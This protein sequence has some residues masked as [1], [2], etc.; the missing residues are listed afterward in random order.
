MT[1]TKPPDFE[2]AFNLAA[3]LGDAKT[4]PILSAKDAAKLLRNGAQAFLC[5]IRVEPAVGSVS[6][7][8][9]AVDGEA[10]EPTPGLIPPERL[11][12]LK[13]EFKDVFGDPTGVPPAR[14]VGH[15]IRLVEGAGA[16]YQKPYRMSNAQE[17]EA[18]KQV[19][20]ML[21]KGWIEP[22]NSPYG[23]P[24]LFVLK[25]DG[26]MRMVIDYR[27]LNKLTIRDRYPLPRIDDML[28]RL[29][30]CSIFSAL[31]LASGYY[32]VR[33]IDSDVEKTAFIT[34]MGQM[35]FRVLPMGLCNA[36]ST[37]QR[38]VAN[39]FGKHMLFGGT[40]D[41][42]MQ[43]EGFILCY[44]DDILIASKSAEEHEQHLRFVL[45]T[46]RQHQLYAKLKKCE[47]NMPELKWVGFIVGRDGLRA[48]PAKIKAI[49]DFPLPR[50]LTQ[51]KS[52]LGLCVQLRKF[53]KH[54]SWLVAPLTDLTSLAK[55]KDFDWQNWTPEYKA[56]FQEVQKVLTTPP[57]LALVDLNQPFSLTFDASLVGSG[58]VLTQNGK[59]VAYCSR[60]FTPAEVKYST[61]ERELLALKHACEEWRCYLEGSPVE[62]L[63]DHKPL[64]SLMTKAGFAGK[65]GREERL[66]QHLSRFDFG[67]GVK[68][69]PGK[70][71]MADSLSRIHEGNSADADIDGMASAVLAVLTRAA[72]KIRDESEDTTRRAA[73]APPDQAR[74]AEALGRGGNALE[75]P[76]RKR[77][78]KSRLHRAQMTSDTPAAADEV[79]RLPQESTEPEAVQKPHKSLRLGPLA[80][81]EPAQIPAQALPAEDPIPAT[82]PTEED[83]PDIPEMSARILA[84]YA[85]DPLY[86]DEEWLS[87]CQ[88]DPDGLWHM[89]DKTMVPN[90]QALRADLIHA[91]HD[92]PLSG[93]KGTTAT[94]IAVSEHLW[95]PSLA[96]DVKDYVARCDSCQRNKPSQ[97]K[98]AGH[99]VAS[100]IPTRRWGCV[101]M[102][103]IVKLPRTVPEFPGGP[104]YDS[105]LVFIDRLSK[106]VHLVPCNESCTA[107]QFARLFLDNVVK[108]HGLPDEVISDRGSQFSA[109]FTEA[110]WKLLRV[111]RSLSTAYHPQSNGQVERVNRVIEE[112]MR[113]Y[114]RPGHKDW[115][116]YLSMAE[117]AINNTFQ[118]SIQSSPAEIVYGE[119]LKTPVVLELPTKVP[120]VWQFSKTV[121]DAVERAQRMIKLAQVRMRQRVDAHR[122]QVV[123]KPGDQ[124]LLVMKNHRR[125]G[126]EG[127]RKLKP[128]YTGPY[129]VVSIPSETTVKLALPEQWHRVHP[130]FH[131][132]LVK[133]YKAPTE[134]HSVARANKPGPPPVAWEE[135]EPVFK[136]EQIT[137]SRQV[138]V[139]AGRRAKRGNKSPAKAWEYLVR[140]AG[141]GPD[142]DTWEPR[143]PT[144][145]DCGLS[146]RQYKEAAG[147]PILDEDWDH[148]EQELKLKA[149]PLF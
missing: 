70:D 29:K 123:Y 54:Y 47:F 12:A 109:S 37:F 23:A 113:H 50:S 75:R 44:L 144:L 32:Q 142:E 15:V 78:Q 9:M 52:F 141:H 81:V 114:V 112:Y 69:I 108:L 86:Q 82:E 117:L 17:E 4:Q 57:V 66:A 147:L 98:P 130:V 14:G 64:T 92:P 122:R 105:I 33:I 110:L 41:V 119:K 139:R 132:S 128:R 118:E 74:D 121:A 51:L 87:G 22:A 68:W 129:T 10:A 145:E 53:I 58:G 103:Y 8:A 59:V 85:D 67:E 28:D 24:L 99:H 49:T 77:T 100:R 135:G 38:M 62:L 131:V 107:P 102:D 60:K 133:P 88:Q 79:A 35:Q 13:E 55:S 6:L 124:V 111:K 16:P 136:V 25:K 65:H 1:Y 95:W 45:T 148:D 21:E 46:L 42:Q 39:I 19:R 20:E 61:T 104:T 138:R 43:K 30:G 89:G 93:H 149:A 134:H 143:F 48:D 31:D 91:F 63:T 7:A 94:T 83:M 101:H 73:T 27:A 76:P 140:W 127:V 97:Q 106:M 115:D 80:P 56:C 126:G 72:R 40:G 3:V 11:Q 125:K 120:F 34:P 90:D 26:T 146:I 137:D 116:R 71:N 96:A 36:P 5:L 18:R 84:A 2:T